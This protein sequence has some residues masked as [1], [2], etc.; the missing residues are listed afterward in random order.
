MAP[1]SNYVSRSKLALINRSFERRMDSTSLL[2]HFDPAAN[3][4][5]DVAISGGYALWY[6]STLC[7]KRVVSILLVL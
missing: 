5:D 2:M 6:Q 7:G 1:Q 3:C 4:F